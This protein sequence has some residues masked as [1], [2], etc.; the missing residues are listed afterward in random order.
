MAAIIILNV[1]TYQSCLTKK[2]HS[3][4]KTT[5]GQESEEADG[6][7]EEEESEP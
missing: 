3:N 6:E 2:S 1:V 5:R 7:G 4:Q